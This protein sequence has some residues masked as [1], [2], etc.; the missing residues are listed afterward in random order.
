MPDGFSLYDPVQFLKTKE[1]QEAYLKVAYET[2]DQTVI[3]M[4]QQDVARAVEENKA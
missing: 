3:T 2:N 4:A 1:E